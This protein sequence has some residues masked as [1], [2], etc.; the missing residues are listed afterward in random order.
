[1][2]LGGG[3][4]LT[5]RAYGL[6]CDAVT[7]ID[8]V[9]ADGS[10]HHCD[11]TE[12][13]DL[14]WACRG[15]GGSFGVVTAFTVRPHVLPPDATTFTLRFT[16]NRAASA[17]AT[18]AQIVPTLPRET[19]TAARLENRATRQ[20]VVLG[21]HLG[22]AAQTEQVLAP[23]LGLASSTDI[24][25]RDFVDA[26]MLEAGCAHLSVESC[27]SHEIDDGGTRPR[28]TPFAASSH[29]FSGGL[30]AEAIAAAMAAVAAR[31]AGADACNVQFD[32]YGGAI[33]DQASD[34]T[35]FVHRDAFCAAQ[36]SIFHA[37]G[38]G[39][40]SRSW[41]RATREAMAPFS[42]GESYQNYVDADLEGWA[43]A[44]YGSNLSRLQSVKRA[45]DPENVF[46]FPQS[47][48]L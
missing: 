36:Y 3:H 38:D 35:A 4:G 7:A 9:C 22:T 32:S 48:P 17:L 19:M 42:N 33:A 20:L 39:S 5:S 1:L 46:A 10:V 23:L 6:T 44:Y 45:V 25:R 15:G 34:A 11:A 29:Y 47:I 2:A 43:P 24:T 27:H 31:P 30:S 26:L 28:Q 18:W 40:V 41:V 8:I 13:S 37:S 12:D 16:W 21:L 14:F